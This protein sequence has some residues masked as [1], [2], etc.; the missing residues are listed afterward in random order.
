[1]YGSGIRLELTPMEIFM[2]FSI[3]PKMNLKNKP[4]I[5][6]SVYILINVI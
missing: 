1:M 6:L 2:S 5:H 3:Y 4:E